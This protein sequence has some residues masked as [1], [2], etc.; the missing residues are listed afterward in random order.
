MWPQQGRIVTAA[1]LDAKYRGSPARG[2]SL[3]P[4]FSTRS[5]VPNRTPAP[6]LAHFACHT[7]HPFHFEE[8]AYTFYTHGTLYQISSDTMVWA[9]ISD[10]V[11]CVMCAFPFCFFLGI[12]AP[13]Y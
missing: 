10:P 6:T 1:L 12:V 9:I 3:P 5:D 11:V 2:S 7:L 4:S 8:G 13:S